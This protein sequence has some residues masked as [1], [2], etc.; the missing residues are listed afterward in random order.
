MTISLSQVQSY[1]KPDPWARKSTNAI[2]WALNDGGLEKRRQA[3]LALADSDAAVRR[4][5]ANGVAP[6]A[7]RRRRSSARS[8]GLTGRSAL[9]TI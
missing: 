2:I 8:A 5:A 4:A 3:A 1:E 9:P 7:A 6:D